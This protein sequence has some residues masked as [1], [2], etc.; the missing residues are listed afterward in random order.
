MSASSTI[1]PAPDTGDCAVV[2]FST[3][4]YEPHAR[5]EAV[6]E[7]LGRNLQKVHVEPLAGEAFRTAI[8]L[9]QM[10]GL[11][12]YRASRSA[13]IYRRSRE[14]IE[15]DDVI[16]ISGFTSSYEV[17]HLGRTLSLGPGESVILTG[18]E[19]AF[20]GGPDQKSVNLL[21]VPARTLSPFVA[22]LDAAYGRTIAANNSALRLLDGYLDVLE[23]AETF[24]V[25][26]LRRQAVTHIHDLIALT[27]GAAR[28][29]AELA[30]GRGGQAARLGAIKQDI[31]S[32]LDRPD[33]SVATIAAQHRVKPRWVQRLFE[34]EGT[35]FTEYVLA[36]RLLRAHRLLTDPRQGHLK[37]SAVALDVGFGDLSYF[38]RAFRRRYGVTP[39]ELR[40]ASIPG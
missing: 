31:A 25:P 38:N 32:C 8:T 34:R 12:L 36:Q 5:L 40:A 39:S 22:D 10:P 6:H 24:A 16:V 26:E 21:R 28:D 20:F 3:E 27:I 7:I 33:L 11:S 14:F 13:A 15:H 23:E 17:Q 2:R 18:A 29:A 19:P 9:R 1:A 4:D 30:Q 37:I 35:T